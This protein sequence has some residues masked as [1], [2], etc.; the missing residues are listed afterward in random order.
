[1]LSV[2]SYWFKGLLIQISKLNRAH[3]RV[4][5][6]WHIIHISMMKSGSRFCFKDI[7]YY[8]IVLTKIIFSYQQ[9]GK[10]YSSNG[11]PFLTHH[12]CLLHW[13]FGLNFSL[14]WFNLLLHQGSVLNY[15]FLG[16]FLNRG[17]SSTLE[18]DWSPGMCSRKVWQ[19]FKIFKGKYYV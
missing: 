17:F 19:K 5:Q 12:H 14:C 3:Y 16:Q 9:K 18:W 4:P 10:T 11:A 7:I 15:C 1:M 8:K 6:R 13:L 2:N